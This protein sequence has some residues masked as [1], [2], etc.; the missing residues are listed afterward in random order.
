M[1]SKMGAFE[2]DKNKIINDLS[3]FKT[4]MLED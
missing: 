4:Q 3:E 2:E 1:S